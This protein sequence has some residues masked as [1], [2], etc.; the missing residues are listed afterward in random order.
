MG[1]PVFSPSGASY[2]FNSSGVSS[3]DC[4]GGGSGGI[5]LEGDPSLPIGLV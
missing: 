5:G 4:L 3:D 2:E 1:R